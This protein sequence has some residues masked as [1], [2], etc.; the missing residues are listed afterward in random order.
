MEGCGTSALV[1]SGWG[2]FYGNL[3]P[4]AVPEECADKDEKKTSAC[5]NNGASNGSSV[6]P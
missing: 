2:V 1:G 3:S 5:T 6:E 4:A